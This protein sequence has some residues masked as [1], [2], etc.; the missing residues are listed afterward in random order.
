MSRAQLR[1]WLEA[2]RPS[3]PA[4]LASRLA[5]LLAAYPDQRLAAYA[6]AAEALAGIALATLNGLEGRSPSG[7]DVAMDLL[8]ADAFVTY[9]FEAAAEDGGDV[10]RLADTLISGLVA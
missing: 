4:A 7:E 6:T 8:A 2:R 5:E 1:A 3:P 9:A 10:A